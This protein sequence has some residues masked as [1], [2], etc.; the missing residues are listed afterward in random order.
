MRPA[1]LSSSTMASGITMAPTWASVR[2][3]FW[4]VFSGWLWRASSSAILAG[5]L[6]LAM[7]SSAGAADRG[8]N[9]FDGDTFR[10][11]FRIANIDT[12]EINGKCQA[13]RQLAGKARE[14]TK[15]WLAMGKVTMRQEHPRGID[16]YGR[17]L[18]LVDRNGEDLGEALI[19]AGLARKWDG[20][21]RPWC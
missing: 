11:T 1:A 21:R 8:F 16:P 14:F 7:T 9:N 10:G 18:V 19:A 2:P 13:E 5:S 20:K 15:A 4:T 12:P 6:S 3:N 17:V